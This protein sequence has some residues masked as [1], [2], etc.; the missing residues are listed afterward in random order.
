M[1][2][3]ERQRKAREIVIRY[4][5][6][7]ED[8]A[9]VGGRNGFDLR[10]PDGKVLVELKSIKENMWNIGRLYETGYNI[11]K[12][13]RKGRVRYEV[14]IIR[15]LDDEKKYQHLRIRAEEMQKYLICEKQWAWLYDELKKDLTKLLVNSGRVDK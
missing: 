4:F 5:K 8:I 10:S 15:F 11:A 1:E 3:K 2:K 12:E 13:A 7:K 9:L 14:H 6:D